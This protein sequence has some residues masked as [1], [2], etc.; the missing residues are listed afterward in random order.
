M[1]L[2][3]VVRRKLQLLFISLFTALGSLYII[4][5]LLSVTT[6]TNLGK[7]VNQVAQGYR[8]FDKS[9][10]QA[11]RILTYLS[12]FKIPQ[13]GYNAALGVG[14]SI[15]G[16][17]IQ[18][19]LPSAKKAV[20][21]GMSMAAIGSVF[22]SSVSA[23][24]QLLKIKKRMKTI[25]TSWGVYT[26]M[27]VNALKTAAG[28]KSY[29]QEIAALNAL[30]T[31]YIVKL[32]FSLGISLSRGMIQKIRFIGSTNSAK[33]VTLLGNA[34]ARKLAN[35][36]MRSIAEAQNPSALTFN[37]TNAAQALLSMSRGNAR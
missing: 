32:A 29:A 4:Y 25:E 17:L 26:S 8:M 31:R 10:D 7:T 30:L 35:Q 9:V 13:V 24:D 37:N 3:P 23:L 16:N 1:N 12:K 22:P 18:L 6:S 33:R 27:G 14:G 19:K 28:Y 20:I 34:N 15:A 21:T 36:V 11:I 5:R 2:K